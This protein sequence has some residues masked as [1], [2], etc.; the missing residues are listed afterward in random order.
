[1]THTDWRAL[2]SDLADEDR[3][4]AH[5]D[6]AAD[7]ARGRNRLRLRRVTGLGAAA[8]VTVV[9]SGGGLVLIDGPGTPRIDPTLAATHTPTTQELSTPS[10]DPSRTA[11]ARALQQELDTA[12]DRGDS[13]FA[14]WRKR[15]FA[16]TRSVLD[17]TGDHLTYN[18][19]NFQGGTDRDGGFHLGAN[20]DWRE[21][22]R[23]GQAVVQV[24]VDDGTGS[25]QA[26]CRSVADFECPRPVVRDGATL[27]MGDSGSAYVV[28]H[29]QPDG[30]RVVVLVDTLLHSDAVTGLS[31]MSLDREDV[32]RFVQ[33]DRLALPRP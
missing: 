12:A 5:A 3:T 22:D 14:Q 24:R 29:R 32:Y 9:L 13:P 21:P 23:P 27:L 1:M 8:L 26:A 20:L 15:L 31:E 19:D 30:D 28:L 6:I 18:G 16:T 11:A 17:P 25:D 7:L 10:L 2:L 4:A 33:D